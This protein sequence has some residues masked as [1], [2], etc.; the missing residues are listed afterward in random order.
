MSKLAIIGGT[1]LTSLKNLEITKREVMHTPYG[2]P[3]APMV[4]GVLGGKEVVFLPRHGPAQVALPGHHI[5]RRH[6]DGLGRRP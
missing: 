1:G 4:F 6:Q 3:S 5:V 2:E